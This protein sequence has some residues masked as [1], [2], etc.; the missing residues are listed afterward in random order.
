MTRE[1]EC[2]VSCIGL[3]L[4]E[5]GTFSY[6]YTIRSL[7]GSNE[8]IFPAE[9]GTASV[10]EAWF[11]VYMWKSASQ[12]QLCMMQWDIVEAHYIT[13]VGFLHPPLTCSSPAAHPRIAAFRVMPQVSAGKHW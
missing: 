2:E 10:L 7:D 6:I 11:S 9:D 5:R 1:K 3:A 13:T 4:K 12:W 8:D